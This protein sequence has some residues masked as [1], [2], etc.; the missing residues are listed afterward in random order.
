MWSMRCRGTVKKEVGAWGLSVASA[1]GV[2]GDFSKIPV[3]HLF[4]PPLQAKPCPHLPAV[5][6]DNP[7]LV[8]PVGAPAFDRLNPDPNH[9]PDLDFR[10]GHLGLALRSML[11]RA[12]SAISGLE[13]ARFGATCVVAR[14][15]LIW[16]KMSASAERPLGHQ[17]SR[18]GGASSSAHATGFSRSHPARTGRPQRSYL[19]EQLRRFEIMKARRRENESSGSFFFQVPTVCSSG[20]AAAAVPERAPEAGAPRGTPSQGRRAQS[21]AERSCSRLR[22]CPRGSCSSGRRWR[23]G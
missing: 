11:R 7:D 18:K 10:A 20:S 5:G 1:G 13:Q 2:F 23:S 21:L 22:Q 8:D 15:P 14:F 19:F 12:I 4:R 16:L 6:G 3:Q 9:I 17:S